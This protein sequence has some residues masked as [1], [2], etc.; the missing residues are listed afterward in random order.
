MRHSAVKIIIFQYTKS[1]LKKESCLYFLLILLKLKLINILVADKK[2]FRISIAICALQ[3]MS[4][5]GSTK[6]EH[7]KYEN[8]LIFS[9]VHIENMLISI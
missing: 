9:Y 2:K 5:L 6:Y 1:K 7:H 3:I 8:K 4:G